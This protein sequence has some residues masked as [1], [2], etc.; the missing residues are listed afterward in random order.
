LYREAGT[1]CRLV[2]G[3]LDGFGRSLY[4]SSRTTR[5]LSGWCGSGADPAKAADEAPARA[6]VR[7]SEGGFMAA[8]ARSF[9]GEYVIT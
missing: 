3:S 2:R 1:V 8:G 4:M 6:A 9:S 5:G 7:H